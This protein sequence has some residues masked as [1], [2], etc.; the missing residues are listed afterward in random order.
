MTDLGALNV[1]D[2]YL[3][4]GKDPNFRPD[5]IGLAVTLLDHGYQIV[6]VDKARSERQAEIDA[7]KQIEGFP[8]AL[9]RLLDRVDY[10]LV[11]S[12][13]K[14][15]RLRQTPPVT[16]HDVMA[17]CVASSVLVFAAQ[18]K[19]REAHAV[20]EYVMMKAAALLRED[21]DTMI[22]TKQAPV[23]NRLKLVHGDRP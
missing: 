12:W 10:E 23:R 11:D 5:G 4:L 3:A 8:G 6:Q 14:G 2:G 18:F 15:E 9:W 7:G 1:I 17:A 21:I 19:A 20:A 13:C 22:K 16:M